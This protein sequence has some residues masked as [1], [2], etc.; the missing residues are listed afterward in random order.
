[1]L[2]WVFLD[3]LVEGI[4]RVMDR[5]QPGDGYF[6]TGDSI[7]VNGLSNRS[8]VSPN[9]EFPGGSCHPDWRRRRLLLSVPTIGCVGGGYP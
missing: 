5:A 9:S 3:D 2:R 7:T 8:V 1:M 6:L 4:V